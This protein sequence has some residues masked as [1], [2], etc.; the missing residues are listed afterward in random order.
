MPAGRRGGVINAKFNRE[1]VS[2]ASVL[3]DSTI[4]MAKGYDGGDGVESVRVDSDGTE[5]I[6]A[7]DEAGETITINRNELRKR[8]SLLYSKRD[9]KPSDLSAE[10]KKTYQSILDIS[11]H[12]AKTDAYTSFIKE[13][14]EVGKNFRGITSKPVTPATVG[15]FLEGCFIESGFKG[16]ANCSPNCVGSLAAQPGQECNVTMLY[17]Q[18]DGNIFSLIERDTDSA[19]IYLEDASTPLT[20]QDAKRLLSGGLKKVSVIYPAD[21]SGNYRAQTG[22]HPVENIVAVCANQ[23]YLQYNQPPPYPNNVGNGPVAGGG[24]GTTNSGWI[25]FTVIIIIIIIAVIIG[26]AYAG[27]HYHRQ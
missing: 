4:V 15:A 7:K 2:E 21:A 25:A 14:Q 1:D 27:I 22:F 5:Y 16:P 18:R 11:Q 24:T 19:Y 3:S 26:G 9:L 17:K 20:D 12:V 23:A 13:V 8:L 10:D 6:V